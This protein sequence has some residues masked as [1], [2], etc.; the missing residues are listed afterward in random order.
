MAGSGACVRGWGLTDEVGGIGGAEEVRQ[1]Q[2]LDERGV[3]GDG[4]A[5]APR[6]V[7]RQRVWSPTV[8]THLQPQQPQESLIH[9]LLH[10]GPGSPV[11]TDMRSRRPGWAGG[12]GWGTGV[13]GGGAGAL[14]VGHSP[15]RPK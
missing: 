2:P 4:P 11:L 1:V 13:D 9:T 8:P 5:P 15:D 12:C 6:V 3:H 7:C 10:T 14:R